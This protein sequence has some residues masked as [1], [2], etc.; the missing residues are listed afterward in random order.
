MRGVLGI[1]TAALVAPKP[2]LRDKMRCVLDIETAALVASKI[3][4]SL[5]LGLSSLKLC[6]ID[7][8][9]DWKW[10]RTVQALNRNSSWGSTPGV[11]YTSGGYNGCYLHPFPF[12]IELA[13]FLT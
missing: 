4:L 13:L 7:C 9:C 10:R 1:E 11:T 8:D 6:Q 2:T 5:S 12:G 3:L